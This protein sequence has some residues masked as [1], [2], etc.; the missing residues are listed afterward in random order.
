MKYKELDFT[1]QMDADGQTIFL[2]R[3]LFHFCD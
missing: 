2:R 1:S 3:I